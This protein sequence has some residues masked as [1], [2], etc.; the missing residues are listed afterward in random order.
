MTSASKIWTRAG[1]IAIIG[2][3]VGYFLGQAGR[4]SHDQAENSS[5]SPKFRPSNSVA[6][7]AVNST[8]KS[9]DITL[10]SPDFHD[11][12]GFEAYVTKLEAR[13][14]SEQFAKWL[15]LVALAEVNFRASFDLAASEDLVFTWGTGAAFVDPQAAIEMA[16]D[17]PRDS[18]ADVA[19]SMAASLGRLAPEQGFAWLTRIPKAVATSAA[20][21]F[22]EAWTR[23]SRSAAA[24]AAESLEPGRFRSQS[25]AGVFNAW[26][27][28][29]Q[30][31]MIK[32]ALEQDASIGRIAINSLHESSGIRGAAQVLEVAGQ[33]PELV[34]WMMIANL[35]GSL[36][37]T[38]Q[39]GEAAVLGIPPGPLRNQVLLRYGDDLA[40]IDPKRAWELAQSLD[41]T[42]RGY[43]L[44]LSATDLTK[45]APREMATLAASGEAGFSYSL[46]SVMEEW[47]KS[48]APAAF[49]W[50]LETWRTGGG[51]SALKSAMREWAKT[52][53]A[54]AVGALTPLSPAVRAHIVP[55]IARSWG[56]KNPTAA[57]AWA[58]ALPPIERTRAVD[59]ALRGWAD[60]DPVAAA[61]AAEDLPSD[62]LEDSMRSIASALGQQS[63][64][65]AMQWAGRL[66]RPATRDLATEEVTSAW[67]KR[68]A[69]ATSAYL[70]EMPRGSQRDH[71]VAGFVNAT[72]ELDP[73]TA[74]EWAAVID[75]E[76]LRRNRL[77]NAIRSWVK[78]DR[79]AAQ[80][81]VTQIVSPSLREEM[82]KQ[83][84]K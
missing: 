80:K 81:F 51:T 1:A 15:A 58:Q 41:P 74:S 54:S 10:P 33:R 71:A 69:S 28:D 14:L 20:F 60:A 9:A 31:G 52:D 30:S 75:N 53:A 21:P 12:E 49:A 37:K 24:R 19:M 73:A 13:G 5:P 42:D 3:I 27:A 66:D 35:S 62:G 55:E 68:D 65:E 63:P 25:L 47:T 7:A 34:D 72:A 29:D 48:D 16:T 40:H 78:H 11:S 43:F 22:F 67:G 38:G 77:R 36:A 56:Q 45:H 39:S 64:L 6:P 4:H 61:R 83:T 17:L 44:R 2:L 59:E 23:T 32:W 84:A 46:R 18:S 50:S 8:P 82:T 76:T 57:M 70:G 26:G 79:T